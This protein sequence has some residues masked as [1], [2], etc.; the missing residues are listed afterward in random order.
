TSAAD[1]PRGIEIPGGAPIAP[2]RRNGYRFP[3]G[4]GVFLGVL[5]SPA[6][7]RRSAALSRTRVLTSWCATNINQAMWD[8]I[9]PDCLKISPLRLYCVT[10]PQETKPRSI[11]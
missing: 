9:S 5:D 8:R 4:E 10:S 11:V 7:L 6:L 3:R 2:E 1:P